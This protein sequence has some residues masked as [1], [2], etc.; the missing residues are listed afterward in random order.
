MAH[1]MCVGGMVL[2]GGLTNGILTKLK[3]RNLLE[4]WKKRHV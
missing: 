4:E 3:E 2:V 1:H